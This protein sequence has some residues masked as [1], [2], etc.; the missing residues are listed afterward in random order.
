M[1]LAA[2]FALLA[3]ALV[4]AQNDPCLDIKGAEDCLADLECNWCRCKARPSTCANY[5]NSQ[6]LVR[7][8]LSTL[9]FAPLFNFHLP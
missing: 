1:R 7:F 6:R 5:A 4:A 3:L 8:T 9:F 2:V